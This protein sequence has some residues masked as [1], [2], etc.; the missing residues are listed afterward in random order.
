MMELC[1]K[2]R[3]STGKRAATVCK[4]LAWAMWWI[5]Q[6]FQCETRLRWNTTIRAGPWYLCFVP[7]FL[8]NRVLWDNGCVIFCCLVCGRCG[9]QTYNSSKDSSELSCWEIAGV[10][11]AGRVVRSSRKCNVTTGVL[12]LVSCSWIN[13]FSAYALTRGILSPFAR[14]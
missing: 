11:V 1:W 4:C 10:R 3:R 6:G 14:P 5:T 13:L 7:V 12:P 2:N 8:K 9:A